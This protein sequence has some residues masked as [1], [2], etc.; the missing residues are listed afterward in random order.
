M[1]EMGFTQEQMDQIKAIQQK[2][3]SQA[4]PLKQ[5]LE[6]KR[7]E[8]MEYV[9]SP[10]ATEAQALSKQREFAQLQ[11]QLSELRI[12]TWFK[13]KD[14]MSPEQLQRYTQLHQRAQQ[15]RSKGRV[16]DGNTPNGSFF[17]RQFGG[18]GTTGPQ[19]NLW[20]EKKQIYGS[21]VPQTRGNNDDNID[22]F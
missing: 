19:G 7:K 12:K 9:S 2:A 6:Q 21:Q 5:T 3:H 17:R 11:N 10:G 20:M 8:M 1:Q 16:G 4:Q 14:V 15:F 22:V 18:N 13:M